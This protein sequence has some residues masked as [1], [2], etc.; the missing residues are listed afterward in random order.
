MG[1]QNPMGQNFKSCGSVKGEVSRVYPKEYYSEK[2]HFGIGTFY[3]SLFLLSGC[4]GGSAL[5]SSRT[6]VDSDGSDPESSGDPRG[7]ARLKD[8]GWGV[9]HS[10]RWGGVRTPFPV[11]VWEWSGSLSPAPTLSLQVWVPF[12]QNPT[13]HRPVLE[14]PF[15]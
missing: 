7:G 11:R 2:D 15:F 1:I 4:R 6:G 5:R 9:P 12:P 10:P 8:E 13:K 3:V 14:K